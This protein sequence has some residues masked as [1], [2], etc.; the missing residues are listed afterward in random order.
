MAD[1]KHMTSVLKSRARMRLKLASYT[2]GRLPASYLANRRRASGHPHLLCA[3]MTE[4]VWDPYS[5]AHQ[6]IVSFWPVVGSGFWA[7]AA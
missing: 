4:S 3:G 6:S 7:D 5:I 2:A 1:V